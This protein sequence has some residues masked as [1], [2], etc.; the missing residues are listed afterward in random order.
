LKHKLSSFYEWLAAH[1]SRA[2]ISRLRSCGLVAGAIAFDQLAVL[3][4]QEFGE[5]P[6]DA[7]RTEQARCTLLQLYKQRMGVSAVDVD[8]LEQRESSR[9]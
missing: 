6:L 2:S 5:V 9:R 8:L 7:L 4:D 1:V 3:A